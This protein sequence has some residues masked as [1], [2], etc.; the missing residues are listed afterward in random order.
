MGRGHFKRLDGSP[1]S[2]SPMQLKVITLIASGLAY[3]ETC[4]VLA[5]RPTTY[6]AHRTRALERL[7]F[8]TNTELVRW[9]YVWGFVS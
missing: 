5:I 1:D 8:R 9:C 7:G 6:Y 4:A 2:L 3:K